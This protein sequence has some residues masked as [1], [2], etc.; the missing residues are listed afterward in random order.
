LPLPWR[1]VWF[2]PAAG[3][4]WL[5]CP[6]PGT[7]WKEGNPLR[8]HPTRDRSEAPSGRAIPGLSTTERIEMTNSLR[9]GLDGQATACFPPLPYS[10]P[11]AF[12]TFGPLCFVSFFFLP[13]Q[14]L[15]T[16]VSSG[17]VLQRRNTGKAEGGTDV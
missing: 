15:W 9:V 7:R 10:F 17:E 4:P 1:R 12:Q 13:F 11:F 3:Y 2:G 16:A 14:F 6:G 8:R 5:L